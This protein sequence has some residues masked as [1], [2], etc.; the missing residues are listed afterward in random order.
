M[1]IG[2]G[3]FLWAVGGKYEFASAVDDVTVY[4]IEEDRW[5]S[6]VEGALKPMPHGV[7]GA[8]WTIYKDKIYSFGGKTRYHSGCS[9]YVQVYDIASNTWSLL[10]DMPE[11]RSKLGKFY[12]VFDNRYVFLFGGDCIKGHYHRVNWNWKFDL[13]KGVWDLD[14]ADAPLTQSFPLPTYHKGWLYYSTGNTSNGAFNNYPG[15][16][17]QRYNPKQDVWEVLTPSPIPITDGEGDK[18]RGELHFLGGWNPNPRYYNRFKPFYKGKVGR[19]HVVY[20]YDTDTWRLEPQLPGSWHHGGAKAA[21]G[22]LWRY[23][24]TID[25]EMPRKTRLLRYVGSSE[26]KKAQ[27]T[28]KIFRWDGKK[29]EERTPAPVRKMN[30]GCIYSRLGPVSS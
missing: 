24:G 27:H 20:N 3:H 26:L 18:W 1:K 25:E 29:W 5:Y 13:E 22:F 11:A 17:N 28:N 16:V 9:K 4:N 19:Q 30:F 6:S 7:Q 21:A 23:L 14:V 15:S 12:P 2:S 8:G 10:S